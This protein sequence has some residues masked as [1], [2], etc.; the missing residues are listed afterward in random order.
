MACLSLYVLL[1]CTLVKII[2]LGSIE[3]YYFLNELIFL[4]FTETNYYFIP[5]VKKVGNC[6]NIMNSHFNV[7][8]QLLCSFVGCC[9]M[10]KLYLV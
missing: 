4:F 1:S 2:V 5:F 6:Q 10:Y 9:V 3:Q 7:N 8:I